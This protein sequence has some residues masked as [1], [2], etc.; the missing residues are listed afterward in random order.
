MARQRKNCDA[1]L[2]ITHTVFETNQS[3]HATSTLVLSCVL[4]LL[5]LLWLHWHC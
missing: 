1:K 2:V 3:G 4:M 5:L